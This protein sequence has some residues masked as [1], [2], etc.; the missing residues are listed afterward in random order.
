VQPVRCEQ[1]R[2]WVCSSWASRPGRG[3]WRHMTAV[4]LRQPRRQALP[5]PATFVVLGPCAPAH[6]I[7][8]QRWSRA[9]ACPLGCSTLVASRRARDVVRAMSSDHSRRGRRRRAASAATTAPP[10]QRS[11]PPNSPPSSS[12]SM[13]PAGARTHP[14]GTRH[15]CTARRRRLEYTQCPKRAPSRSMQAASCINC[16]GRHEYVK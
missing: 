11:F 5:H 14:I 12:W 15:G 1:G 2:Y 3:S 8:P 6:A 7:A 9:T 16:S 4:H 13:R 10:R